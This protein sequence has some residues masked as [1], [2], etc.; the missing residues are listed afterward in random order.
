MDISLEEYKTA[1][2]QLIEDEAEDT[3]SVISNAIEMII[4]FSLND[5]S[6]IETFKNKIIVLVSKDNTL[7][8][9]R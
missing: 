7:N 9:K 8:V 2:Q 3:D 1:I 4:G 5:K 6:F